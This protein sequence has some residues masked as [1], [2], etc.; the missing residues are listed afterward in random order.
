MPFLWFG[1]KAY[2]VIWLPSWS[3]S[4]HL[5]STNNWYWYF[6]SS[7]LGITFWLWHFGSGVLEVEAREEIS[8]LEGR[9]DQVNSQKKNRVIFFGGVFGG[10]DF[11][12]WILEHKSWSL[13]YWIL[14]GYSF[15]M[16]YL[17][18]PLKHNHKNEV[19]EVR[20]E[21]WISRPGMLAWNFERGNAKVKYWYKILKGNI[22]LWIR[23]VVNDYTGWV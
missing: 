3:P 18:G 10:Q 22:S 2:H 12:F 15:G 5:D 14:L 21:S 7:A 8:M 17:A 23:C 19:V 16:A 6:G 9:I 13:Q 4:F 20:F 1:M 11:G